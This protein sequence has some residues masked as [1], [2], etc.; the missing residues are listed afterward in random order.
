[1]RGICLG[2]QL[3]SQQFSLPSAGFVILR[4][5]AKMRNKWEDATGPAHPTCTQQPG[6][7]H[8]WREE[9]SPTSDK[10]CSAEGLHKLV[11]R[12]GTFGTF[13]HNSQGLA[14][15]I[16]SFLSLSLLGDDLP[17]LCSC[18]WACLIWFILAKENSKWTSGVGPLSGNVGGKERCPSV[19]CLNYFS[20]PAHL[21]TCPVYFWGTHG[22]LGAIMMRP[23]EREMGRL[24]VASTE[25]Q[26][27]FVCTDTVHILDTLSCSVQTNSQKRR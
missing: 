2:W 15:T 1:M 18:P 23:R 26:C 6:C 17:A 4:L 11:L 7:G 5:Q 12:D 16:C 19:L 24:F 3:L 27:F 22:F 9:G 21:L 14:G 20:L 8:Q 13:G 10:L 25:G